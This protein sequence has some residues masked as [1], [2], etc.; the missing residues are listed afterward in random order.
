MKLKQLLSDVFAWLSVIM[1][2]AVSV[3]L[4]IEGV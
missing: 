4:M 1:L 3:Y 2:A